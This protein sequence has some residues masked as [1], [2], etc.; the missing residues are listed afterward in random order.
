MTI[1]VQPESASAPTHRLSSFPPNTAGSVQVIRRCRVSVFVPVPEPP[2]EPVLKITR[3]SAVTESTQR[4]IGFLD[5]AAATLR[6]AQ[7]CEKVTHWGN[8]NRSAK[9]PA[10]GKSRESTGTKGPREDLS[11]IKR[12]GAAHDKGNYTDPENQSR[13]RTVS[14][15]QAEAPESQTRRPSQQEEPEARKQQAGD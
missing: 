13:N 12:A 14:K 7:L 6:A 2:I 11:A 5:A 9:R 10:P 15:C 4:H 1:L 3:Q 8:C